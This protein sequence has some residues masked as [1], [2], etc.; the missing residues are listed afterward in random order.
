MA[1]FNK[2]ILL[3]NL[4][5]DPEVRYIPS[6]TAVGEL[7][8]AVN[9]RFRAADGQQHD[10]TCFVRI[11]V[12]GRQAETCGEYLKK[13]SQVLID[14]RLK[15]DQW[16][17]EG[18][19]FSRLSVVA[20]RVQFLGSPRRAEFQ[21]GGTPVSSSGVGSQG[22]APPTSPSPPT[23]PPTSDSGGNIASEEPLAD[24]DDNLPF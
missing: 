13:G 5:R 15:Y 19:K 11:T 24:D 10:E 23:P 8:L 9:R 18:Q 4:T 6:G 3:G 2:V 16:E 14:G 12:W 20:T 21:D 17:K 22:G 1:D 7:G